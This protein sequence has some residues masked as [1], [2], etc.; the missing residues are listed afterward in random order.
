MQDFLLPGYE[1]ME[2]STQL[3]IRSAKRRQIKVEIL[4]RR[5]NFL[6]LIQKN[7]VEY[8]I[9]ATKTSLDSYMAFLYMEDKNISKLLLRQNG[10]SVP[11]SYCFSDLK[12]ALDKEKRQQLSKLA[13]PLVVKPSTSNYGL[14]I[15][16]L[17]SYADLEEYKQALDLAFSYADRVIVEEFILGNEYRFLIIQDECLA[18][19]RR[20][21]ANVIGDGLR[22]IRDL[23]KE[24]NK[25][26]RRGI[27][28]LEDAQNSSASHCTPMEKIQFSS[29][30]K[31][32]LAKQGLDWES[33]PEK[34]KQIFLRPNSNVST[35]GEAIDCTDEIPKFYK[36]AALKAAQ[37]L[38]AHICGVDMIIPDKQAFSPNT[39]SAEK[40]AILEL[41]FNPTIYIH[42]YP[43]QGQARSVSDKVLDALGFA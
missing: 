13:L 1:D 40:Y 6:R 31:N 7:R 34:N 23:V 38:G 37:S 19:C 32:H 24:K 25:D 30:E 21:P 39:E 29:L 4:D 12:E 33:I 42:E 36:Q 11:R 16:T 41:N 22:S 27:G 5:A 28:E 18:V 20:I 17:S 15:T 43:Y 10:L 14:G 26:P 9:Q 3:I 8:I 2:L 35:G